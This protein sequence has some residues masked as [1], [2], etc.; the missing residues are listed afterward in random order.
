[1]KRT[2]L[3]VSRR[4]F[5]MAVGEVKTSRGYLFSLPFSLSRLLRVKLAV[6]IRIQENAINK[7]GIARHAEKLRPF[8]PARR[9][10]DGKTPT[11][12]QR[13]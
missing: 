9:A 10:S 3:G 11:E 8:S 4:F 2:E 12:N 1:M 13:D 7:I 6:Q 5:T